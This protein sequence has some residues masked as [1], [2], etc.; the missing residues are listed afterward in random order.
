[1]KHSS[2]IILSVLTLAMLLVSSCG[3]IS[4]SERLEY[5]KPEVQGRNILIED[6]TGQNCV[7]C[8]KATAVIEQLQQQYGADTIIAVAIHSG[9]FGVH[10]SPTQVGLATDLGDTY[11]N[12]WGIESQPN[13]IIDRS[14]GIMP[15]DWWTTR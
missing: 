8:P 4:E 6:F 9:Y 7:N 14:D 10:N 5:V 12:H 1:M 2:Y 11:Y 3:D 15:Y 13:G